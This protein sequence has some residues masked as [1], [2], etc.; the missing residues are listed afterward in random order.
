MTKVI[1]VTGLCVCVC[2]E[3]WGGAVMAI[4][5]ISRLGA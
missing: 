1:C 2:A 4:D 5:C 3:G